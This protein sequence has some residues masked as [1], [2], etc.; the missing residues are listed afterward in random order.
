MGNGYT[1]QNAQSQGNP[2]LGAL[3]VLQENW[4]I[5]KIRENGF[6]AKF[7]I[8]ADATTPVAID[9]PLGAEI[10]DVAVQC[11]AS[12]A[13]GTATV[14]VGGGGTAIT[15]AIV[16]AVIDI[17][18]K[19]TKVVQSVKYVGVDGIEVVTNG[20]SDRGVVYISYRI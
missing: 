4:T 5:E 19:T 14:Q 8:T 10:V 15:S 9:I 6:I 16:C 20:A 18:S 2:N 12:N 3:A 1:Q 11:S 7:E 17:N 13:S